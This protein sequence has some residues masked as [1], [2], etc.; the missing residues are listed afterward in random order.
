MSAPELSHLDS[1]G[2]LDLLKKDGVVRTRNAKLTPLTGGVS[3]EIY[4]VD[5]GAEIFVVKRALAKLKVKDEWFADVGRNGFERMFLEYVGRFRPESVPALRAASGEHGYFAM[6][7]LD[8]SFVNWKELLLSGR[9]EERHARLAGGLIGEI[10]RHSHGEPEAKRSFTTT[11]G[12]HKLRVEPYLITTGARHPELQ[13]LFEAEATRL[14][15]TSECLV[16][17]DFS[18][19]NILIKDER[20]VLLDCEVAWYGDPAFDTAFGLNHLFLKSLHHLPR[21]PPIKPMIA[22][23]WESYLETRG[24][25]C[26]AEAM[27]QRTVRLLL[28]LML[29]RVD[30]KSPVEYLTAKRQ[31]FIRDFVLRELPCGQF[32]LELLTR[33]WFSSLNQL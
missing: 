11:P 33:A 5:D 25:A 23:L 32:R 26:D 2:F 29:A 27:E 21:T 20:L 10:H 4:R 30:G 28:M 7:Y 15:A 17:G 3:S 6:E 24:P 18:P 8:P 16:H 13:H 12:F 1:S 19:K 22:A 14:E 9:C 31:Q